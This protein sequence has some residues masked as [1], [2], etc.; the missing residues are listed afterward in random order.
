MA[1][2]VSGKYEHLVLEVETDTPGTYSK[3]CGLMGFT[4]AR[5]ATV[6]T[7]EIP[8]DCED[9]SLP[10]QVLREVRATDFQI[11]NATA[12]WAQSSHEMLLD[13]FYSAATKNIRVRNTNAAVGDTETEA[14][15]ALLTQLDH[16][17]TKGQA[18][19]GSISIQ[20]VGTPTRTAKAA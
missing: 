16:T 12:S 1:A 9:E 19:S 15:A 18:L 6:D 14:G 13:W 7:S 4:F 8:A 5:A 3:I 2:P 17:R 20:F 10:Y 11:S